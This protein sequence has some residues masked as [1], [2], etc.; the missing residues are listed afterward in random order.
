MRVYRLPGVRRDD[1]SQLVVADDLPDS[2][3]PRCGISEFAPMT[4]YGQFRK[5]IR[6][7]T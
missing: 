6:K 2:D 4:S 5:T 3:Q 7:R 1:F